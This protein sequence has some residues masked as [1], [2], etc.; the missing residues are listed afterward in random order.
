MKLVKM[1][2]M[3]I[4]FLFSI[5]NAQDYLNVKYSD[6]SFRNAPV[7]SLRKITF[8]SSGDSINFHLADNQSGSS[9]IAD[10]SRMTFDSEGFGSSLLGI[11]SAFSVNADWNIISVP[12]LAE[13]MSLNSLF[14]AAV[15]NAFY[16]ESGYFSADI[17]EPGKGYWLKFDSQE[18][19]SISGEQINDNIPLNAGWNMIGVYNEEIDVDNIV[20]QPADIITS[21]FFLYQ[22]GYNIADILSPG[23]GY[24]VK[25]AESGEI[26]INQSLKKRVAGSENKLSSSSKIFITDNVGNRT[27]LFINSQ[28]TGKAELPPLPPDGAFDVR[29]AGNMMAADLQSGANII[30]ISGARY[31]LKIQAGDISL[32][33]R[34]IFNGELLDMTIAPGEEIIITNESV[35][36]IEVISLETPLNYNL[37]QNYPNPFNPSTMIKF[38]LP[39]DVKVSVKIFNILGE[40]VAEP[41]NQKME[42]GSHTLKFDG[43]ALASGTYFYQ[44]SAGDFIEVKKMSLIK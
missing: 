15:S 40:V 35:K 36:N 31:P 2:F 25:S 22:Q 34:D 7:E 10:V 26:V 32:R 28:I 33:L 3:V 9:L 4:V 18:N 42:A 24:W 1:T 13:D 20:T 14:P 6:G 16:F 11:T 21:S 44:V 5:I 19:I 12:V 41:L 27:S 30:Q 37:S 29:F 8:S 39:E 43:S 38:S 23:Y 17:L